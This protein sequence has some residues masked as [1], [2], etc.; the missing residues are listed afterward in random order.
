MTDD[1][2]LDFSQF[3]PLDHNLWECRGYPGGRQRHLSFRWE[4]MWRPALRVHWR[5]LTGRHAWEAAACR[6]PKVAGDFGQPPAH[7]RKA[8]EADGWLFSVSCEGCG[9]K[10]D[11]V[12][13]DRIIAE[14]WGN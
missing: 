10:P 13:E 3:H 8:M 6:D 9:K 1:M 4:Y 2:K 5:H 14:Q 12:T 11:W 7:G